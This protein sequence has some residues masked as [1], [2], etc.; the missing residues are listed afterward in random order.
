MLVTTFNHEIEWTLWLLVLLKY[1]TALLFS[2]EFAL[3]FSV[4]IDLL[5][6]LAASPFPAISFAQV[7]FTVTESLNES[8]VLQLNRDGNSSVP[9]TVTVSTQP[10]TAQGMGWCI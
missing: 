2:F 7:Q 6:T 5:C 1:T 3:I 4:L 10:Q 9:T 8:A